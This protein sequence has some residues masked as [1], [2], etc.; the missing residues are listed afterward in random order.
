VRH[1]YKIIQG[2]LHIASSLPVIINI[3]FVQTELAF[4][5][6]FDNPFVWFVYN[7]GSDRLRFYKSPSSNTP[8]SCEEN[9]SHFIV[10]DLSKIEKADPVMLLPPHNLLF[11][12]G[13]Y[14]MVD[15]KK[16]GSFCVA[17][18]NSRASGDCQQDEYLIRNLIDMASIVQHTMATERLNNKIAYEENA[19]I[20]AEILSSI[21][22]PL[23]ACNAAFHH[24][25]A[26]VNIHKS[27]ESMNLLSRRL[28]ILTTTI[29]LLSYMIDAK[30]NLPRYHHITHFDPLHQSN[31]SIQY[32]H[33][34]TTSNLIES[35]EALLCTLRDVTSLKQLT[36]CCGEVG[37]FTTFT[38]LLIVILYMLVLHVGQSG[39]EVTISCEFIPLEILAHCDMSQRLLSSTG[40][41]ESENIPTSCG[42]LKL[43]ITFIDAIPLIKSDDI[44]GQSD[45]SQKPIQRNH[46]EENF[47]D[48]FN[49]SYSEATRVALSNELVTQFCAEILESVDGDCKLHSFPLD[50]EDKSSNENGVGTND[51]KT[52][53]K[54]I[55]QF[56]L[57][58]FRH[59]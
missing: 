59:S 30:L 6:M 2:D 53:A 9:I 58:A 12:A 48:H 37:S 26:L 23:N 54:T 52:A 13:A 46:L 44:V 56:R 4:I 45:E 29:A 43:S 41:F 11:C 38:D 25:Q 42:V 50:E 18:R 32:V 21:K 40:H 33:T 31:A 5:N 36:F 51:E 47:H 28:S 35:V 3:D 1:G 22:Y 15:G 20:A 17:D 55:F 27:N 16:V 10:H 39:H 19:E 7:S 49:R 34:A 14:I 24:L 8:L 57:P